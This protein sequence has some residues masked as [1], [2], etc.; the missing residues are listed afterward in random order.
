VSESEKKRRIILVGIVLVL[1]LGMWWW[2]NPIRLHQKVQV[3]GVMVPVPFGWVATPSGAG[4][5]EGYYLRHAYN[6]FRPSRSWVTASVSRGIWGESFAIESA[7]R[8]QK[9]WFA[10]ESGD[11]AHYS[12]TRMFDLSAGKYRSLCA[13]GTFRS[14]AGNPSTQDM[15]CFVVG[16]PVTANFSGPQDVDGDAGRILAS[17]E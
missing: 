2:G 6:P 11:S 13:E 17:L 15:L 16:T 4:A 5:I 8:L 14:I 7:R 9:A 12:N 1:Y 10:L 3:A